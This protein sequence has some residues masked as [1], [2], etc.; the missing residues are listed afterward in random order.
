M[1][2]FF[3]NEKGNTLFEKLRGIA[4]YMKDFDR[5]LAV[6]GFFRS[7]GY[8]KLRREL[9]NVSEI[10]ILVGI[11][12]D[13]LLKKCPIGEL[14]NPADAEMKDKYRLHFQEDIEKARYDQEVEEGI[15][16]LFDDIASGKLQMRIHRSHNLHAKFY[17]C[18]PNHFSEHTGGTVIM[19]SSNL[20]DS[21]M[22]TA[23]TNRYE[24][25]VALRDYDDVKYCYD[26]FEKLWAD[27]VPIEA[28]DMESY[29]KRTYLGIAPTPYELYLKVLIDTFGE[30]VEDNFEPELP[31]GVLDLKYQKDAAIQGYQILK[32]HNGLYLADVVGLG[33][34]MV[35][36]MVA[37]RFVEENG[38][39]TRILIVAPPTLRENWEETF[40]LFGF[41]DK[42]VHFVSFG[43]LL[44]VL[45]GRQYAEKEEYH[46]II[47]DEAHGFRNARTEKYKQLQ[48]ICK[49]AYPSYGHVRLPRKAVMLLSATPINNEPDD[50]KSQLL[51]FQDEHYCTIE[52]IPD[53]AGF[54]APLTKQYKTLQLERGRCHDAEAEQRIIQEIDAIYEKIRR[55]LIEKITV[56]RTRSNILN[57]PDYS[58][59]LA[60]QGITF[61]K[62]M[63]P[64]KLEYLLHSETAKRFYQT[65]S[66]LSTR[67]DNATEGE[68]FLYY[69]RYRG[70]EFLKPPF[71]ERYPNA[72]QSARS[73]EGIYRI[74]MVKRLESSFYA[75]KKSLQ[76]LLRITNDM[77]EMFA[78]D[79]VLILNDVDVSGLLGKN[80]LLDDI[81][82]KGNKKGIKSEDFL[83]RADNFHPEFLEMLK[84]DKMVLELLNDDWAT[85]EED[86]KFDE[87]A[88]KM[89]YTFF[90]KERNVEGK[91]VVFSES[92][93]T[94]D[95]LYEKITKRLGRNDV[96]LV[97]S[98]N[99]EAQFKVI[100]Q[101]F[102]ANRPVAE[103][104]NDYNII[105]T[106]DVLAEGVN[107]HRSNVIVNYDS[108]WNATRL[109]QRIGRVNRI[110]SVA[111]YIFNY[112]FYPSPQGDQEIQLYRNALIKLQGFHSAFGEDSQIYSYEEVVKEFHLYDPQVTDVMD[113]RIKLLREVRQLYQERRADYNRIKAL[114][115]KCRVQRDG[116]HSDVSLRGK[117]LVF[118][119][120][121]LKSEFYLVSDGA[122]PE[123][124]DFIR[125]AEF[126]RAEP[127]ERAV[128]FDQNVHHYAHVQGALQAYEAA[129][130]KESETNKVGGVVLDKRK[131]KAINYLNGLKRQKAFAT[132]ERDCHLLT[133]L[134]KR[135]TISN[136]HD[137]VIKLQKRYGDVGVIKESDYPTLCVE[138]GNLAGRY[139]SRQ[140]QSFGRTEGGY[141]A[142]VVVSESFL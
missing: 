15:L 65:L 136:L 74:H 73:L 50:F 121:A 128:A 77:I 91:L 87:F 22:G 85:V 6:S 125:A 105:L 107:L 12:I 26:E 135:G 51:L 52:G 14:F 72:A 37:K 94:V 82:E 30:Q 95:Y 68:L 60:Q 118:I 90:R 137:D 24:L 132:I 88:Q 4:Q 42:Y 25:N 33:K 92:K 138:F 104:R 70:I 59:D 67:E 71:N 61:P 39:R 109:M 29:K 130:T 124:I 98:Q 117:S 120:S 110:G 2:K 45:E 96:L 31:A 49:A 108:P 102:D 126:L 23:Q 34:T 58:A 28:E 101:N 1:T 131:L 103:Q 78:Q 46:L 116:C 7:S 5:F 11:N 3:N 83:Y 86:P 57:D 84:H 62:V 112:I 113:Q 38:E 35:A 133:T 142:R 80:W 27:A 66:A 119:Q 134:I 141:E 47:V 54:F 139:D 115:M 63:E 79:K 75:F 13:N 36:A 81:I 18:L 21:G 40:K 123:C 69:A 20:S 43:S 76:N 41:K 53:I 129:Y 99:R 97:N 106:T 64:Q 114:P 32:K 111:E 16:Q 9:E 19:G 17:L 93:D 44:N 10:R 122:Q 48:A 140:V 100:S 55:E 8:F 127:G 56:R 89:R